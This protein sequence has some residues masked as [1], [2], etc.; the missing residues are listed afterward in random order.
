MGSMDGLLERKFV[1]QTKI[2]SRT[3]HQNGIDHFLLSQAEAHVGETGTGIL[4]KPN[5]A[6]RKELQGFDPSDGCRRP[7]DQIPCVAT[8]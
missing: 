3:A 1:K 4:R 2:V 8:R 5:A 7:G 6:V